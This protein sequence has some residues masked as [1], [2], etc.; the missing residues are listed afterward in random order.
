[1]PVRLSRSSRLRFTDL[2][3]ADEVEFFDLLDLD[4]IPEQI[5]DLKYRVTSVD[6]IDLLAYRFYSDPTLWWVI[7]RANDMHLLPSDLKVGEEIRI[8]SPA[9]VKNKLFQKAKVK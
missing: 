1:M 9:W 2:I 7:A 5:D 4:E 3:I 8:P 6:R